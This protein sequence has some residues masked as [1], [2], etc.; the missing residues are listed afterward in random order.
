MQMKY[1][2]TNSASAFSSIRF[3]RSSDASKCSTN[4]L[5]WRAVRCKKR[6]N[7]MHRRKSA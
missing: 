5:S 2:R 1:L 3:S 6:A 4:F 7:E